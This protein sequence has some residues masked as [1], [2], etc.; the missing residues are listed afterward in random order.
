MKTKKTIILCIIVLFSTQ[1]HVSGN[2]IIPRKL[3]IAYQS[4]T[5]QKENVNTFFEVCQ[6]I[7]DYYG[8]LSD[9]VD[10]NTQSFPND[11]D[12]K[13]Y[14]AIITAFNTNKNKNGISWLKWLKHQCDQGIK[15]IILGPLSGNDTQSRNEYKQWVDAIYSHIGIQY[16]GMFSN[17]RGRLRYLFKDSKRVEFERPY[18][19]FPI[20]YEQF[21]VID[22]SVKVWL[23]IERKNLEN[24]ESATI[25]TGPNGGFSR[26]PDMFWMDP[27]SYKKKWYLN[28]FIFFE[29][30]L[31]IKDLPRPDPTTL[32]GIRVAFSHID[33]DAFSGP[34]RIDPQKTCAEVIRD[35]VLKK[36]NYPI[37]VSVIVAEISPEALGNRKLVDIAKDI[38]ALPNIE[39]ASH[40]FSHP[41]YWNE[42][43]TIKDRYPSQYGF[44]VKGYT[45]D[46]EKEIVYSLNYISKS[47]TPPDKPCRVMLWSGACDPTERELK[48]CKANQFYNMNGGDTV[49][50][51]VNNSYT[52]VAPLYRKVGRFYQIH[53]GQ[54]NENILTNLWE[55]PYYGFREIIKTMEK[56]NSPRRLKP[57]DIYYHFY[58]GEYESSLKALQTVYEWVL[59]QNVALVYVS[60]YIKM[61]QGFFQ[62][63]MMMNDQGQFVIADY[64]HCLT[65]RFDHA[66]SLP[67][68][69][70]CK[71]VLGFSKQ[72]QGLFV[73]L[74]PD[75]NNAVIAFLQ[76]TE[77]MPD[78]PYIESATGHVKNFQVKGHSIQ[79][80]YKGFGKGTVKM[81]GLQCNQMYKINQK[82]QVET[83]SKGKA[84]L[85]LDP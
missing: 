40:A 46:S 10:I 77:A 80:D 54:A 30:A 8:L 37:T 13:E 79:L 42:N 68:L 71:N 74:K 56:T 83:D 1:V 22:P 6:T 82:Q 14:R 51:D 70:K 24:S 75:T 18:P 33:G 47:L 44:F 55:G 49:F 62:A 31:G 72:P 50:D 73:S 81:A 45:F 17:H 11:Q 48:H 15:L 9:Y 25:V 43:S 52:A 28:P 4:D 64:D 27:V 38:F 2:T 65:V 12:M 41:Y 84:T 29:E 60:Q 36:Y 20:S 34:S 57:V 26:Y 76:D 3:L 78:V 32:N 61:M 59:A 58:S 66:A 5:G 63:K 16:K 7:T 53:C 23:S 19:I 85:M 67:D 35:E 21:Q 39:P 69:R